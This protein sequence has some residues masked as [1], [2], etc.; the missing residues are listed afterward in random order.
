MPERLLC[1]DKVRN[2]LLALLQEPDPTRFASIVERE[3]FPPVAGLSHVLGERLFQKYRAALNEL[4]RELA[5]QHAAQRDLAQA[6]WELFG[7]VA[8]D[9][10]SYRIRGGLSNRL[11]QFAQEWKKPLKL[12]EVAYRISNLNLGTA[13][14]SFGRVSF[15]TMDDAQLMQWGISRD[16]ALL[17]HHYDDF[18]SQPVVIIQVEAADNSRAF[19]TGFQEVLLSLDLLRLAGVRGLIFGLHDEMFLWRFEG[20]SMARQI[21]PPHPYPSWGWHR[22]LRPII[23]DMSEHIRKGLE[24]E[25]SNLLAIANGELPEEITVHLERAIMWIS[26]SITRERL[27]DKVV[28]LCTALEIMLLPGY[29]KGK[30]GQMIDFRHRL[31]GGDWEP[32]GILQLYELRSKIIHGSAI[33][34]SRYLD[35]WY[36]L[37]M[38][39]EALKLLVNHSKR[40]P[41]VQRLEELIET[42]ESER[43]EDFIHL[44]ENG[45][46]RG[47]RAREIKDVALLRLRD[48][49]RS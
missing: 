49:R 27:D 19:E 42:I 32:G 13:S 18:V 45:V 10:V 24:P 9:P 38:C 48:I 39:F 44:F 43:L 7:E 40:N 11:D 6:F 34:V 47:K 16:D 17:S 20:Q 3:T 5:P 2:L 23:V 22:T 28:D 29:T 21:S 46:F 41:H 15:L 35:Y 37:L 31:I 4:L 33:N 12:F 30:K 8:S 26:T 1:R 25:N 14:F 36:L